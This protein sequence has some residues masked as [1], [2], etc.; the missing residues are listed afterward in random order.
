M[1]IFKFE[2]LKETTTTLKDRVYILTEGKKTSVNF[3]Y[4]LG[5]H[6]NQYREVTIYSD[7]PFDNITKNQ[8]ISFVVNEVVTF[9]YKIASKEI[10]FYKEEKT[11]DELVTYWLYHSF[12]PILFT[13]EST[14]Y[15]LHTAA[16]E[17]NKK[18]VLFIANSFGGK[19]TLT[20]YFI[21]KGHIMISD[22]KVA[23]YKES[24][25]I[26][27]VPSFPYHRP[28][29]KMEDLGIYVENFASES[30]PINSIFNL[31]KSDPKADIKIKEI[32]GVEKFK[33]LKYASDTD[34]PIHKKSRFKSLTDIA[35]K[36][37]MYNITIP[38]DLNRLEEVYQTITKFIKNKKVQN[39]T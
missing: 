7:K 22:D 20:D 29:R 30:R 35:N 23:T 8:T 19:S 14:Y 25:K 15:I 12:L 32:F 26:I 1:N 2:I 9:T 16:I 31:V 38:W 24:E 37:N 6:N 33:V 36:V 10:F 17:I 28:Y 21:K 18:S 3:P 5:L 4:V 34:L 27:A 39:D 13:F 11:N